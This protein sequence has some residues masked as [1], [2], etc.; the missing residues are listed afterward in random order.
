MKIQTLPFSRAHC[1]IFVTDM[2][3]LLD[4][5]LLATKFVIHDEKLPRKKYYEKKK[6]YF[7]RL[8]LPPPLLED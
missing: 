7:P 5:E 8:S 1:K 6:T 3:K 2:K 4:Y